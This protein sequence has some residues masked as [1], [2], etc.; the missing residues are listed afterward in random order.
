MKWLKLY[1]MSSTTWFIDQKK[2]WWLSISFFLSTSLW[3]TY[4]YTINI[5]LCLISHNWPAVFASEHP[6]NCIHVRS[7]DLIFHHFFYFCH[8]ALLLFNFID[9]WQIAIFLNRKD[10]SSQLLG[11][12]VLIVGMWYVFKG[13]ILDYELKISEQPYICSIR[14]IFSYKSFSSSFLW[15]KT[16]I[17]LWLI[18]TAGDR[19]KKSCL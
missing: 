17:Q 11:I 7:V 3:H 13:K 15:R 5:R 10:P 2:G 4:L 8:Y 18:I 12:L 14:W 19:Q 6:S 9:M 1:R 16:Y